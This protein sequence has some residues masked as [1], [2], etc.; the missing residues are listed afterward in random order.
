MLTRLR[1]LVLPRR[2][3]FMIS[4][5]VTLVGAAYLYWEA[6]QLPPSILRGYPGDGFFPRIALAMILVCGVATLIRELITKQPETQPP[7]DDIDD[8]DDDK[9]GPI[10]LDL[11]EVSLIVALSLLYMVLLKPLGLEIAT[12]LF[13]FALLLPRLPMPWPKA[14]VIAA[15]GAIC[16][17]LVVYCAF[18]LGLNVPLPLKFLPLYL[19]GY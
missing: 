10:T 3:S 13:M 7:P 11:V 12:S 8:A 2:R 6:T 14:V 15:L 16:T 5:F 17:T 18:V 9:D 19:G 4:V 1:T